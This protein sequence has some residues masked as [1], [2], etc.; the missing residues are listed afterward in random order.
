MSK[1]DNLIQ[2]TITYRCRV[3]DSTNIVKNGTNRCGNQQYWCNDCGARRVLQPK[4]PVS[5]KKE[6]ALNVYKERASM[7]GLQRS[8]GVHC[9]TLAVWLIELIS[10]LPAFRTSVRPAQPDDV[11]E[12]DELRSFVGQREQKRWLWIALC[13]RTRQVAAF[14]IG[15]RSATTCRKLWESIPHEYRHCQTFSDFWHT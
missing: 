15:D 11:L 2:E 3:C 9:H 7:G 14:V 1:L 4:H 5:S 10:Q 6:T 12:L 8:L 13:R